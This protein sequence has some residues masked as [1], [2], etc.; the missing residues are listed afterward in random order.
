MADVF[1]KKARQVYERAEA[2]PRCS[3]CGEA[4][5]LGQA[6]VHAVCSTDEIPQREAW[7][8]KFFTS[9]KRRDLDG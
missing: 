6:G 4:M 2:G 3:V 1:G 7:P 9:R 5:I 8:D